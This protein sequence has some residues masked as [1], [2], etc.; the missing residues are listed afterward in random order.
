MKRITAVE[1]ARAATG[2]DA[3]NVLRE[4]EVRVDPTESIKEILVDT[5]YPLGS[6]H[7]ALP[8]LPD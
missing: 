8:V 4:F 5:Q 3:G 2:V 7:Q 6:K 1:D